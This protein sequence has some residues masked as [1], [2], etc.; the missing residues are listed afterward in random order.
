MKNW[1]FSGLGCY[2]LGI[3]MSIV[4]LR[5]A[6]QEIGWTAMGLCPVAWMIGVAVRGNTKQ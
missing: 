4:L 6:P 1:D 5:D 3:G 2:F